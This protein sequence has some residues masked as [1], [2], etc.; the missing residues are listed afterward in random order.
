MSTELY[1]PLD[2]GAQMLSSRLPA[3]LRTL[4]NGGAQLYTPLIDK[5]QMA[6]P[7]GGSL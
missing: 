1:K 6:E 4:L 7:L 3:E 2:D 5:N